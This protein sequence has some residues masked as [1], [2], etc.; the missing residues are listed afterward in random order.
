VLLDVL[1]EYKGTLLVVSHD[2]DFLDRLVNKSWLFEGDGVITELV[3]GYQEC[4]AWLSRKAPPLRGGGYRNAIPGGANA[5]GDI[6]PRSLTLAAPPQG[7]GK[8]LSYKLEREL[9]LLPEQIANLQAEIEQLTTQLAQ[10]DF[11]QRDPKGFADTTKR[12]GEAQ[13]ALTHAE[14]RWLELEMMKSTAAS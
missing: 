7:G 9:A 11:Y 5:A 1:G 6:P 12:V 10:A 8:K 3:G 4:K 2:R 13:A 14:E